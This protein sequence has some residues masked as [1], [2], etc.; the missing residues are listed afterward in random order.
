MSSS[1]GPSC[2]G[3]LRRRGLVEAGKARTRAASLAG[4]AGGAGGFSE[5]WGQDLLQG[6]HKLLSHFRAMPGLG[7]GQCEHLPPFFYS[8][9][10]GTSRRGAYVL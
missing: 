5:G 7:L 9:S 10:Q 3:N 8:E 2:P 4:T 6:P 1:Y